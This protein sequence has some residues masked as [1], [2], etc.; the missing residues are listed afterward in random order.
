[1]QQPM[2]REGDWVVTGVE[3]VGPLEAWWQLGLD[4]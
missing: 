1:V 2:V 4:R 3:A